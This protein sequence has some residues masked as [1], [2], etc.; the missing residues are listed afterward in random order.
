MIVLLCMAVGSVSWILPRAL[1]QTWDQP[2]NQELSYP[3]ELLNSGDP[4]A[5]PVVGELSDY[6]FVRMT[7]VERTEGR[8]VLKDPFSDQ[9]FRVLTASEARKVG[10]SPYAM[11]RFGRPA[12]GQL[13]LTFDDGPDDVFTPQ[14]LD[15]LASEN[16]PATF[17]DTGTSIVE[18][19]EVFRRTVREGHMVGNH[20]MTHLSDWENPTFQHREELIGTDRTMRSVGDYGTR[21]FRFPEGNPE[22]KPLALLQAQQLGYLHVNMDLDTWDWNYG[23]DETVP[24]PE[25]D[26]K[27]HIVVMHAGGTDRTATVAML[28]ELIADAK[29]QG[30]TFT[31]LA[32]ILPEGYLPTTQAEPALADDATAW[33]LS[34]ATVMPGVVN[35]WLFWF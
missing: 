14:I 23:P 25:L 3:K 5:I 13:M 24:L 16:V 32:P 35:D 29:A 31:T 1:D 19:P 15:V 12:D 17:F 22:L 26:G 7:L 28:K 34:A 2:L 8:T 33:T 11:E 27:G 20:T 6:A 18:N 9:V 4:D 10:D 21:L 30:Y